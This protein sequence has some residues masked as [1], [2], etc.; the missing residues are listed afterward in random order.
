[1]GHTLELLTEEIARREPGYL[2]VIQALAEKLLLDTA[3]AIAPSLPDESVAP[4]ARNAGQ[5]AA[6]TIQRYLQDN[7]PRP[8]TL[9]DVAAQVHLSE[10]QTARVFKRETGQTILEYL[11]HLR[12]EAAAQMLLRRDLP[13]KRIAAE[14]GY[15]DVHYFAT[16][17][18]KHV[19][20]TPGA[21]RDAGGTDFRDPALWNA[22]A[23]L[24]GT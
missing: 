15:P 4:P 13:I 20:F 11:T 19:G 6:R 23:K 7:A 3:R 10:R 2:A 12:L 18:R 21:F 16:L 14:V 5:A 17:F 22:G 1:M 9:R 8:I 24:K